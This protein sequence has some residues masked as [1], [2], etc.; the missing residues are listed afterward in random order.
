MRKHKQQ[1]QYATYAVKIRFIPIKAC[2][3]PTNANYNHLILKEIAE[4]SING[5]FLRVGENF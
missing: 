3:A 4:T 1:I 5:D 2:N